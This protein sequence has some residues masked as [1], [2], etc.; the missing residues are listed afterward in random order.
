MMLAMDQI[1]FIADG[2]FPLPT[3]PENAMNWIL[4]T[5]TFLGGSAWG[6][7]VTMGAFETRALCEAGSKATTAMFDEMSKTNLRGGRSQ[8]DILSTKCVPATSAANH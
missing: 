6:P 4:I 5:M 2:L 1:D 8:R 7:G 3:E